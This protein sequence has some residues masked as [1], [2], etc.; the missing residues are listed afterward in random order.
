MSQLTAQAASNYMSPEEVCELVPG[1]T[2]SRL[3][4]LRFRGVGP[5]FLKPTPRTVIYRKEDV[6]AWIEASERTITGEA[7]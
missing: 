3:A 2:K 6:V 7:A 5:K 1:M 4:Q